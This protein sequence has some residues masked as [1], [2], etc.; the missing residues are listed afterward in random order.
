MEKFDVEIIETLSKIVRV[1][2]ESKSH[3]IILTTEMY[4]EKEIIL[5]S[6]NHIET[7]FKKVDY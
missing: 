4:N 3:A 5:D 6:S 2:A 7:N 1:E